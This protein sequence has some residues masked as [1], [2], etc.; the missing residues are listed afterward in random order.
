[1]SIVVC[2]VAFVVRDRISLCSELPPRPKLRMIWRPYARFFEDR[3]STY[4]VT[5]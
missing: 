3:V 4:G 2:V 1:M 5:L